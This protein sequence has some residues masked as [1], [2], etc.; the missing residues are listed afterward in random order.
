MHPCI[1][2][3]VLRSTRIDKRLLVVILWTGDAQLRASSSFIYIKEYFMGA[4]RQKLSVS[5]VRPS[6]ECPERW[7]VTKASKL[8]V[9]AIQEYS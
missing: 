2:K 3:H 1:R 5:Q 7:A 9:S 4:Y 6:L 8:L